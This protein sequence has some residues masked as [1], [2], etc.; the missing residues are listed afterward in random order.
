[1]VKL[2]LEHGADANARTILGNDTALDRAWMSRFVPD[3]DNCKMR[4][5]Y[6]EIIQILKK[7]MYEQNCAGTTQEKARETGNRGVE[8]KSECAVQRRS[9]VRVDG[10]D[11]AQE[12]EGCYVTVPPKW[13]EA[14]E[15]TCKDEGD[16]YRDLKAHGIHVNVAPHWDHGHL[17]AQE[18]VE[19]HYKKHA[20]YFN[21]SI[22]Q[23]WR[24]EYNLTKPTTAQIEE[25]INMSR[26]DAGSDYTYLHFYDSYVDAG[27]HVDNETYLSDAYTYESYNGVGLKTG[28]KA[29]VVE[30]QLQKDELA[31]R[32]AYD[33][34]VHK[35]P[36]LK[37]NIRLN[38][39]GP[40][41]DLRSSDCFCQHA[42]KARQLVK[43]RE[44]FPLVGVRGGQ[45]SSAEAQSR[46]CCC[47]YGKPARQLVNSR[48][49]SPIRGGSSRTEN[50]KNEAESSQPRHM[51]LRTL[52]AT[53]SV[54]YR[55]KAVEFCTQVLGMRVLRHEELSSGDESSRDSH[56]SSLRG[57]W[58]RTMIGYD[59]ERS[60][61]ALELVYR[62]VSI[63]SV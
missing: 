30:N 18:A 56:V 29:D 27:G 8:I 12:P 49:I 57:K 63:F 51:G 42:K 38:G 45:T 10:D 55:Q 25:V 4:T 37:H 3:S 62:C 13:R 40:A 20:A 61:F 46:D 22:I 6:A 41:R 44:N 24:A 33:R 47:Q 60:A 5:E 7:Q 52:H 19:K 59:D 35:L 26:R 11:N 21:G 23:Q 2:L 28:F 17:S 50:H 53:I 58:S 31:R 39:G 15:P 14:V 54:P 32:S 36:P 43:A 16:V 9:G 48:V 34:S 1:M